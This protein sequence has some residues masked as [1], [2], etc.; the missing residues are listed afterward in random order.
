MNDKDRKVVLDALDKI[1]GAHFDQDLIQRGGTQIS[2][3][4][5][6]PVD[7]AIDTLIEF[8]NNQA[9]QITVVHQF[10]YRYLDGL[11]AVKRVLRALTGMDPTQKT[12]RSLFGDYTPPSRRVQVGWE[13]WED[14]PEGEFNIT[15]LEA[16]VS[17]GVWIDEE[18]GELFQVA[19]TAPKRN[20][21]RVDALFQ[22]IEAQLQE[23][24]IYRGKAIT[25]QA[26]PGFLDLSGVDESKVVYSQEVL[27]QLNA[28]V[29]SLLEH[30]QAMRDNGLPLKR[31]VLFAGPYGTG[32]TLGAYL[33]AKKAVE[34]GWTLIFVRPG[35]DSLSAAMATA[36]LYQPA[37]VFFED[38]DTT[39]DPETDVTHL[40]DVFDGIQS[41]GT[42]IIAIFTTNHADK[43]HKGLMR[44]GRLDAVIQIGALDA[45]G[46][47]KLIR[48]IV[49]AELLPFE[50]DREAIA[51]AMS[52]FMPAFVKE[53]V[54]RTVRYSIARNGGN[55]GELSNEDFVAAANGLRPQLDLMEGASESFSRPPIDEAL[56]SIVTEEIVAKAV[57][58]KGGDPLPIVEKEPSRV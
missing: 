28:N 6:M 46:I 26:E 5:R 41:K 30:S 2:L 22:M 53:A 3:P 37:V 8:K 23:N 51:E 16:T 58:T 17:P 45:I 38:V 20:A 11:V 14:T 55:L 13:E 7:E 15:V 19:V 25:A 42:E 40:L 27:T 44:P 32:K 48:S 39:S 49:P 1:G 54:D 34:N 33:T 18:K 35:K 47:E 43:L 21:A 31:A 50:L 9:K 10:D 24:S 52:G 56:R 36:K 29:W 4:E 12:Y 57:L